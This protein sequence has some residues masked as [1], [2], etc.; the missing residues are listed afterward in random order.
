[1]DLV[2]KIKMNEMDIVILQFIWIRIWVILYI[3][4]MSRTQADTASKPR[5]RCQVM[6]RNWKSNIIDLMWFQSWRMAIKR[7]RKKCDPMKTIWHQVSKLLL[8]T[9]QAQFQHHLTM[10]WIPIQ[11]LPKI[12]AKP[13]RRLRNICDRIKNKHKSKRIRS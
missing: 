9:L 12:M 10:G 11:R 8:Q 1:M 13:S 3:K 5:L 4:R 2:L 6:L 7:C